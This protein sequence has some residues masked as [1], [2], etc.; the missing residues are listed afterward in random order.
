METVVQSMSKKSIYF[1]LN[2]TKFDLETGFFHRPLKAV[3]F[4]PP[5]RTMFAIS[6]PKSGFI[7]CQQLDKAVIGI[8]MSET[9]FFHE[10]GGSSLCLTIFNHFIEIKTF[11]K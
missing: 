6:V 8:D 2:L 7:F 5:V 10:F 1:V 3:Y 11:F 9:D 4:T